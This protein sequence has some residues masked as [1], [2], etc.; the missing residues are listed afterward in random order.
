MARLLAAL[1]FIAI[2]GVA[3]L[4]AI[5]PASAEAR[6]QD[7]MLLV[8][9]FYDAGTSGVRERLL[10]IGAQP[11]LEVESTGILR[12]WWSR[13]QLNE[14]RVVEGVISVELPTPA[15]TSAG[16]AL[17]EGDDLLGAAN[18]RARFGV[19][20][21]GVR[22]AVLSD[23]I[24]NLERAQASGDAPEL[25]EKC[26]F[27]RLSYRTCDETALINGWNDEG[28]ALDKQEGTALIE[29]I[30][31]IAPG[32]QISFGAVSDSA[33]HQSMVNYFAPKVDIIVDNLSFLFRADQ[34]SA[35]SRNTAAALKHPDWPL[36]LYVTA[37]GNWAQSHWSGE[38]RAGQDGLGLGLPWPGAV[39]QFD[40][41]ASRETFFGM[42][43]PLNVS[44][45]DELHL[46]LLWDDPHG[47]SVNDYDLY[48]LTSTGEVAAAS[49]RRQGQAHAREQIVYTQEGGDAELFVVIQNH[50]N[51]AAPVRFDL[52]AVVLDARRPTLTFRTAEGSLLA[53][54][55]AAGALTVGAVN[56]GQRSAANY[57]SR[58]PT[59]NGAIKPDIASVDSVTVSGATIFGPRFS[60]TSAA[61]PHVA[62]VGALLLEAQPA[63]LSGNGGDAVL[64]RRL[65]RELLIDTADDIAPLGPDTSTG[66]GLVNAEAAIAAA[67]DGVAV[68]ASAADSGAGA[69]RTALEWGA[70]AILCDES[71]EQRT[72]VLESSLPPMLPGQILDC[73]G[74]TIDALA[75][76]VGLV[77]EDESEVWGVTIENAQR[78]GVL[79]SGNDAAVVGVT[80]RV[81]RDGISVGGSATITRSLL[82][83]NRDVGV[84]MLAFADDLQ[85]GRSRLDASFTAA[86]ELAAPIGPL[87]LPPLDGRSGLSQTI[88]GA[89]Y[90]DGVPGSPDTV[91]AVYLDRRL[92]ASVQ[93]D[94]QSEFVVTVSGPGG[95]V[96]FSVDG[97]PLE[98]RLEFEPGIESDM[99]LHANSVQRLLPGASALDGNEFVGNAIG[100]EV[101]DTP[102]GD[103][104]TKRAVVSGNRFSRNGEDVA[105]PYEGPTVVRATFSAAGLSV[106]GLAGNAQTV[107]LYGGNGKGRVELG[108]VW[109]SGRRYSFEDVAVGPEVTEISV[110]GHTTSGFATSMSAPYALPLAGRVDSVTPDAGHVDGGVQVEIC[111]ERLASDSRTPQVW[112]GSRRAEVS[113]FDAECVQVTTPAGRAGAVDITLLPPSARVVSA[114]HAFTYRSHIEVLTDGENLVTWRGETVA[115]VDA[116][117]SLADLDFR[118]YAWND[119]TSSFEIYSPVLPASLNTLKILRHDQPLWIYIAENAVWTA[120]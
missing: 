63:L 87:E 49:E 79:V 37:A 69:L 108:W 77:L 58:G 96:R 73:T 118:A 8:D 106:N 14:L 7:D 115:A 80:A 113:V 1:V 103:E 116:F 88:R 68:V 29:I 59:K 114:P 56:A 90:V 46:T 18:A 70:G 60:G 10:V 2:C 78:H 64:E 43:N 101:H 72:I 21:S 109:A 98:Q 23:G 65:V 3:L 36:R 24:G 110:M 102:F 9:V 34:Q 117:A 52:F 95:E 15:L 62:A 25:A 6:L 48:L 12:V 45:G 94:E 30:H 5:P 67:V 71:A 41:N 27:D 85:V 84:R 35:V 28:L 44:E 97:V 53:Q 119:V 66:Y 22:I 20:G 55:D 83:D 17:T 81:N 75:V 112:F 92:A 111:G 89:V 26:G 16:T 19:D 107:H 93:V 42:A 38:W 39:Q 57:S 61:A 74:W 31:D 11:V 13:D 100:I 99:S 54:S 91:V 40:S 4:G 82:I 120:D 76:A 47:R 51:E 33:Q 50:R 32:A 104:A 86:S 105:S